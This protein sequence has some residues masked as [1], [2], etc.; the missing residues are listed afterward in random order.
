MGIT[1]GKDLFENAANLDENWE[2]PKLEDLTCKHL[3]YDFNLEKND[4][5]Q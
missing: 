5:Q 4:N 3:N 2:F 1:T